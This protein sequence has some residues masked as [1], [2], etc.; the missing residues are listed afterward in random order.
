MD[1][2]RSHIHFNHRAYYICEDSTK[3]VQMSFARTGRVSE[4]HQ[5]PVH[6]ALRRSIPTRI[7]LLSK[8]PPILSQQALH[9][10]MLVH[11]AHTTS[12]CLLLCCRGVWLKRAAGP[13]ELQPACPFLEGTEQH[14][15]FGI[16]VRDFQFA[17]RR[18]YKAS[19]LDF[20]PSFGR[21]LC[22][23]PRLVSACH[24]ESALT[25][26]KKNIKA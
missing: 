24:G 23:T 25:D 12:L 8:A 9:L 19:V 16:I 3:H 18:T 17:G 20:A 7:S 26:S 21:E 5:S 4:S 22:A 1:L 11:K 2:L 14:I 13:L 15:V 10:C 6:S